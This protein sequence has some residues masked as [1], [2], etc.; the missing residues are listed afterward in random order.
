MM[1]RPQMLR[2]VGGFDENYFLYF[3]ET[4]LSRRARSAGFAT[5]TCP[6]AA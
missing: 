2:A 1:L 3:E 6:T 5:R 4:E